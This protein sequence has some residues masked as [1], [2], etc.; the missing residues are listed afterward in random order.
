MEPQLL[1]RIQS[2]CRAH[3]LTL[4]LAVVCGSR[5]NGVASQRSDFDVRGIVVRP[6]VAYVTIVDT[7]RKED[8]FSLEDGDLDL[9]LWD[10]RKAMSL[11]A[12]SNQRAVEML[13]SPLVLF[14]DAELIPVLQRLARQNV[15]PDKLAFFYMNDCHV[16]FKKHIDGQTQVDRKRYIYVTR[17]LLSVLWLAHCHELPPA[18]LDQ[19]LTGMESHLSAEFVQETRQLYDEKRKGKFVEFPLLP[20]IDAIDM[21]V[22]KVDMNNLVQQC[23]SRTVRPNIEAFDEL[24]AKV[25]KTRAQ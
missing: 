24:L 4:L 25:I 16:H 19:L 3:H 8:S 20:R 23:A 21:A 5:A 6:F 13:F 15:S 12:T 22:G 1:D 11:L 9:Q 2:F 7:V 18:N 10:I 14:Q 17:G